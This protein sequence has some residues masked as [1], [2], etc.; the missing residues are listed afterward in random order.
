MSYR[1]EPHEPLAEGIKRIALEQI[2]QAL[3]Q[4]TEQPDG[5]DEAVHDARKRFKKVRAVLRL[6]R[7]EIGPE[8]YHRENIAFRDAGRR[9]SAVR[10]SAVL[11]ETLDY[12]AQRAN[13]QLDPA[14]VIKL[15]H[16]FTYAHKYLSTHVLENESTL[17]IVIDRVKQARARVDSW[18]I[19]QDDFSAIDKGLRRVYK[20]GRKRLVDAYDSPSPAN[21]HEWRKRTKYLWYHTRILKPLWPDILD[22]LA[23]QVHDLSDLLGLDHDLAVF[24]AKLDELPEI[25]EDREKHDLAAL[26]KQERAGLQHA[27]HP[28]GARI[29]VEKP[30]AFVKRFA[31]YWDVWQTGRK[32][33]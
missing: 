21:F 7:D 31:G 24:Q 16:R 13:G 17:A 2:E 10:D 9:I 25:A 15:R 30:K 4:L 27:A 19:A 23:D 5:L 11:I 28:L 20:R 29:Y 12:L 18:P 22:E 6:V 1:L 14:T 26:V 32:T 3:T 33:Q 8:I